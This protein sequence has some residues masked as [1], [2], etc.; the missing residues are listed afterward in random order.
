MFGFLSIVY[1]FTQRASLCFLP[2]AS[3]V[4]G[5]CFLGE[6]ERVMSPRTYQLYVLCSPQE[7]VWGLTVLPVDDGRG[8]AKR[9]DP[10]AGLPRLSHTL[11]HLQAL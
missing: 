7:I 3:L 5:P 6:T 9:E 4:K 2:R 10:G 8:M 11:C 1:G